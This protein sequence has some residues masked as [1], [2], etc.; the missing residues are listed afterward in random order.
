MKD[1]LVNNKPSFVLGYEV[2]ESNINVLLGDK[3]I[4]TI[5]YSEENINYLDRIMEYQHKMYKY[6]LGASLDKKSIVSSAVVGGVLGATIAISEANNSPNMLFIS[7]A[8]GVGVFLV[9]ASILGTNKIESSNKDYEKDELC[10]IYKEQLEK[11]LKDQSFYNDLP[12]SLKQKVIDI[13][14]GDDH[15]CLNSVNNLNLKEMEK[16]VWK[17]FDFEEK[18]KKLVRK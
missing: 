12:N 17:S 18:N 15:L 16:L 14:T 6:N 8:I 13:H 4:K 5:S 9:G 11:S 1:Y 7:S 3:T 10:L 2:N